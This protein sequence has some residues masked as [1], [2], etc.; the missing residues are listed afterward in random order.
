MGR[1]GAA[2]GAGAAGHAGADSV[3]LS[4][5]LVDLLDRHCTHC[6]EEGRLGFL[7]ELDQRPALDRDRVLSMLTF[8]AFEVMPRGRHRLSTPQRRLMLLE[9]IRALG[10]TGQAQMNARAYF[11]GDGFRGSPVHAADASR[12]AVAQVA[13]ARRDRPWAWV[14]E[15]EIEGSLQTVTPGFIM[16]I[17]QAAAQACRAVD[18][19]AARQACLERALDPALFLAR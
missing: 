4:R 2:G 10:F 15:N 8:T 17:A 19:P 3:P 13:G 11:L 12:D 18:E 6:H 14:V 1:A 16:Q 9:M 7:G 5:P